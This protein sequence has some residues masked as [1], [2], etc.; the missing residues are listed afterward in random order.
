MILDKSDIIIIIICVLLSIILTIY[1][2]RNRFSL[3]ICCQRSKKETKWD[4]FRQELDNNSI[5]DN[6]KLIKNMEKN[7][8]NNKDDNDLL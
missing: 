6:I 7:D 5:Q 8:K 3:N 4:R 1:V 2:N